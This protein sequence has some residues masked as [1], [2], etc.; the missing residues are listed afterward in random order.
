[1]FKIKLII[2]Y[3]LHETIMKFGYSVM[4]IENPLNPS[5]ISVFQNSHPYNIAKIFYQISSQKN[6]QQLYELNNE[7]KGY[8]VGSDQLWNIGIS[9]KYKS[10][11]FLGFADIILKKYLMQHLLEN[12]IKV[13]RKR[14]KQVLLT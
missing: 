8:I 3:V 1:M 9:R 12:H 10:F 5:N 2:Y 6:L 7:C 13:Q 4:M 11:H 14:K